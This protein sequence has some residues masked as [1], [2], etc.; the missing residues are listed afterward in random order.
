MTIYRVK[1]LVAMLNVS[2]QTLWRWER[3]GRFPKRIQLGPNAVGWP[4]EEIHNWL[5]TRPRGAGH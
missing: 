2:S 4:A 3:N 5:I 1:D